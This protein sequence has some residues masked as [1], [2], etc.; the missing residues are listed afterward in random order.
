VRRGLLT[1]VFAGIVAVSTLSVAL[2][3]LIT[4]LELSGAFEDYLAGLPQPGG[5]GMGV[6]RRM[7]LGAAEQTFLASV[8]RGI[9]VGVLI[10]V[11]LAALA[12]IAL[13]YY[14]TRP[15]EHL[16]VAVQA[17]AEGD[18]S[19]RVEVSGP[20]EVERLGEAFNEMAA[21]LA[22]AEELRRRLVGDVAHELR[23]PL[24]ALR[25]QVEGV[26]EGVLPPDEA[27]LASVA[28]DVRYLSRLVSDLQELSAAEAGALRYDMQGLDLS[29][30]AAREVQRA[31]GL[32]GEAV[33]VRL[34]CAG[35]ATVLGD[36]GRL[37]QVLR[38]LLGNA[39]RH[40]PH[41]T[42]TV[43]CAN[44]GSSVRVEV[45]DTG[46]GIPEKDL[47]YVFE[48]FYRA[49]EARA[50]DTGGSGVGLAVTRR[51]VEDHGGKVFA[52][53][54]EGGG[55]IVGFTLPAAIPDGADSTSD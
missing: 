46:S 41:G 36:E 34:D 14:L 4:R 26:A 42:I 23:D 55:A 38:N 3:G 2:G 15:L 45:K 21:S 29:E 25:A 12:A 53:N 35:P 49:D 31:S 11:A 48:R 19:H 54:A 1:Q 30:L 18:L 27:R 51:I 24:A 28:D 10:A 47:P 44:D 52:S 17:V 7:M 8:N 20:Q 50:R 16:T 13:A 40:T 32:A 5:P 33:E 43:A 9:I 37:T 6:G 22:E 39:I